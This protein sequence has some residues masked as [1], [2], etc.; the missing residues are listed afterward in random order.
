MDKIEAEGEERRPHKKD[1][2][3]LLREDPTGCSNQAKHYDLTER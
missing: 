2:E 1:R 3:Q